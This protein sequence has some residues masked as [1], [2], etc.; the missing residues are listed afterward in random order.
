MGEETVM[1]TVSVTVPVEVYNVPPIRDGK[2]TPRV[3]APRPFA[4]FATEP[5]GGIAGNSWMNPEGDR[6][7]A[8]RTKHPLPSLA[9]L[10]YAC[11]EIPNSTGCC[12]E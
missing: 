6:P 9:K 7:G 8:I 2:T 1:S 5:M 3:T 10:Q 12:S 4:K 11:S